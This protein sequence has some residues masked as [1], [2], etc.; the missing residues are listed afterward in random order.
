MEHAWKACKGETPTWVRI[1]PA[2]PLYESETVDTPLP[3]PVE[4]SRELVRARV[5]SGDWVVDAT[6]GNGHDTLLLAQGVG[7]TG[8]VFAF[9]IQPA[10]LDATRTRLRDA[11]A[12]EPC[13]LILDG[14]QHMARLLPTEARGS[15]AAIM[16]NLGWLPGQ[17]KTCITRAETTLAALQVSIDWLRPGGLLTIVVYPSH[18]GGDDEASAVAKWALALCDKAFEVRHLTSHYRKGLSPE[19]WAVRK[20]AGRASDR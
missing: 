6:A 15:L 12:L 18:D 10:A 2:P 4:W 8:R 9:D 1:P 7:A 13:T 3:T 5:A 17:D 16:F 19:C 11:G 20:R 14:H